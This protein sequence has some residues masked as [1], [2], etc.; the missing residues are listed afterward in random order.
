MMDISILFRRCLATFIDYSIIS[1]LLFYY[2]LGFGVQESDGSRSI[3]G[4]HAGLIPIGIYLFFVLSE[5]FFSATIGHS[6]FKIR[7]VSLDNEKLKL[8]QILK[9]RFCDIFDF[10]LTV[11]FL[12]LILSAS[13]KHH[14]RLGDL[15]AG[16]IVVDKDN[17]DYSDSYL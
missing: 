7:I 8:I 11:G 3:E 15:W 16:T 6:I 2:V 5:Y 12:A 9:R 10:Y 17:N 4:L 1:L 14:Q 13:T